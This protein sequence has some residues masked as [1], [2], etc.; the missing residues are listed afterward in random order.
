MFP[1]I[2]E[3]LYRFFEVGKCEKL[4]SGS[5]VLIHLQRARIEKK[6]KMVLGTIGD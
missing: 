2:P 5:N 6:E 3:T 4:A 1:P